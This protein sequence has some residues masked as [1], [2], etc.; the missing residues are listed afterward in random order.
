[1]KGRSEIE[2]KA[3]TK[4]KKNNKK[5]GELLGLKSNVLIKGN[6]SPDSQNLKELHYYGIRYL[7]GFFDVDGRKVKLLVGGSTV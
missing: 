7:K 3:E 2:V 4:L 1:M 6:K 5:T